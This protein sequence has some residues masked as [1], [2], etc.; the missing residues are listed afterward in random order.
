MQTRRSFIQRVTTLLGALAVSGSAMFLTAC[1]NVAQSIITAFQ[2]I[3]KILAQA[4]VLTNQPIIMAVTVE[5]PSKP[6][7]K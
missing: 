6:E 4:G 1:G 7:V 5:T 2:G 3:L